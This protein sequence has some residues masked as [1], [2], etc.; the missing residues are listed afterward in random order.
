M[1]LIKVH[2]QSD[3]TTLVW[4]DREQSSGW[5]RGDFDA[6]CQTVA[7][8]LHWQIQLYWPVECALITSVQL[9]PGKQSN[10]AKMLPFLVEEQIAEDIDHCMIVPLAKPK[11]RTVQVAVLDKERFNRIVALV[12]AQS[13]M[14]L[15]N[16]II[17]VMALPINDDHPVS[18][19]MDSDF[20]YVHSAQASFKTL[21]GQLD[22]L[23]SKMRPEEGEF[24]VS[25]LLSESLAD[26]TAMI[27]ANLENIEGLTIAHKAQERAWLD[28]LQAHTL[29]KGIYSQVAEKSVIDHILPIG[30]AA[31]ALL[32]V[33]AATLNI[34]A[35]QIK[36]Q[37]EQ[38][39]E[40]T[41]QLY[42]DVMGPE[43]RFREARF[44]STVQ[45]ALTGNSADNAGFLYLSTQ[46]ASAYKGLTDVNVMSMAY[47]QRA[48]SLSVNMESG[49]YERLEEFKRRAQA[50]G[51]T[52]DM[53]LTA[54]GS[55][56]TGSIV[57]SVGE[58]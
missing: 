43:S 28:Y 12:E 53:K 2:L 29:S 16:V 33:M 49:D 1:S 19:F 20:A 7:K 11:D 26:Q 21:T 25:V 39:G 50:L 44:K 51:L 34:Q 22:F 56:S 4:P 45:Q 13:N 32:I 5:Q 46:L 47:N 57:L 52:V 15:A 38:V 24:K 31:A 54:N 18:I 30:W 48:N 36:Q 9:P 3:L 14:R 37:L 35:M 10:F 6:F 17:D 42:A 41:Q 40:Q 55:R 23:L 8:E 58:V 27:Y